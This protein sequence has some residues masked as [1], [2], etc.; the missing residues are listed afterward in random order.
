M[1]E[2]RA[3]SGQ[4]RVIL[5]LTGA[6]GALYFLRTLRALVAGGHTVELVLSKYG[7]VTLREETAFGESSAAFVEWFGKA[8]SLAMDRVE[9][10]GHLDQAA[11]IASGSGKVDGMIVTPCSM[12]TLAGIA[13]GSA[14]NLIERAA[15]VVLKERRRLVLVPREAPYSLI[16]LRNMVAVTE[17]GG[18]IVPASPAFYGKPKSFDDLGDFIAARALQLLDIDSGLV[19][20]WDGL[21]ELTTAGSSRGGS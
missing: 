21:S 6:S 4:K 13:H 1:R 17:A 14:S 20:P 18:I 16:H 5:A 7:L 8:H 15:D 12:K 3:M 10:H 11:P 2:H 19:A 9:V